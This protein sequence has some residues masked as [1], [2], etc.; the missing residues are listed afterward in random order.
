MAEGRRMRY[1]KEWATW[2]NDDIRAEGPSAGVGE[3]MGGEKKGG[4]QKRT[5][6]G[7]E[8]GE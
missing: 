8:K 4:E 1:N 3:G 6:N 5:G 2:I 7:E